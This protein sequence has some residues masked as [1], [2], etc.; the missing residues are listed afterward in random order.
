VDFR[1]IYPALTTP[2]DSN[3]E[4]DIRALRMNVARYNRTLLAGYVALGSTGEAVMLSS[5]EGEAVLA[6][7]R[8]NAAPGKRL[9][10]GTGAES[11]AE[12]IR[13]TRKAADLGYEAALV[14]TPYY[15]KPFYKRDAL[16][17]HYR[18]VADASPIPVILYSIPQFAGVTLE[19]PE[20]L[21]LAEHPNIVG[22]KDSSGDVSRLNEVIAGAGSEFQVFTG[23][24]AVVFP[25]L[26]IGAR[27]A[28]LALAA[29]LPE[30]CALLYQHVRDK[31]Y[32]EARDLQNRL[33][34]ASKRIVS[35]GGIPGVK[36]AMDLRGMCGGAARPP[37]LPPSE[38]TRKQ[39]SDL[40]SVL[41]PSAARA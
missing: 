41:E 25:S 13:K 22:I 6:T 27:G 33:L 18:A 7:V 28:I 9:I 21:T 24:A 31:R 15:Y 16:L 23:S 19:T 29:P 26:M 11:T 39:I 17:A 2:F 40:L 12:T 36:Y 34:P 10:A 3:G 20:I 35:D 32:E 5:A 37:L 14:K 30:S 4:L 38:Q 8:E 1:G